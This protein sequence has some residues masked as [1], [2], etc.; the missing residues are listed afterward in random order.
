MSRASGSDYQFVDDDLDAIMDDLIEKYELMTG[1]T[2]QPSSPERL[3]IAWISDTLVETYARIN[4]A[5]NQNIPSRAEG[6]NLDAL[7][8]LYFDEGRPA[9]TPA[10]VTMRFTLS[11]AQLTNVV[12]PQGTRVSPASG[13]P[14]FATTEIAMVAAGSTYADVVCECT[15]DGVAGNGFSAGQ[16]NTL[17]DISNVL[18]YDHCANIDE[19]AGGAD[20][21][22]DDEYYELLVAS[23][24]AYS[25]AGSRGAYEYWAKSVSTSIA[26]VVVN[27]PSAGTVKIYAIMDDGTIADSATKAAILEACS[28]DSVRPLTDNVT[29]ADPAIVS[30]DIALT[31]YLP[32]NSTASTSDMEA[33][34]ASAVDEYVAWQCSKMGKD[35]NPSKLISMVIAAGARRVEVTDPVFTALNDGRSSTVTPQIAAVDTISL[36]NGGTEDD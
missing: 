10:T 11:A 27:S 1:R 31:Y 22:T 34:V 15:T 36:T 20:E 19:S 28:E 25:C 35:I 12:I 7:G 6:E 8:E 29:V 26:D 17:I 24:A 16:I 21:A 30:Y 5:A 3:F 33:A 13:E 14:I 23:Q 18:Y 4:Y 32:S 9:A 2:V